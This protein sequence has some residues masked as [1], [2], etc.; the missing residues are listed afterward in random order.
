MENF[1]IGI[2]LGT[3]M[4]CHNCI[5]TKGNIGILNVLNLTPEEQTLLLRHSD[6]SQSDS[7]HGK[8]TV[9]LHH[10][11]ILLDKYE[12]LQKYCCDPFGL[13]LETKKAS[14]LR[15]ISLEKAKKLREPGW[16]KYQTWKKWCASCRKEKN[17]N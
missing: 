8:I 3:S 12:F 9:C 14:S 5:Y 13:H 10:K 1:F 11:K 15:S 4:D 16:G 6:L 2:H 7:E 17:K